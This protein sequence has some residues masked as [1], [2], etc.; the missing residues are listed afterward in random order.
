MF[1][2]KTIVWTTVVSLVISLVGM[3]VMKCSGPDK[4]AKPMT[5]DQQ[6]QSLEKA[7]AGSPQLQDFI[8]NER[9]AAKANRDAAE[10][11]Q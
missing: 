1:K 5:T 6:L 10:N 9:R 11:P 7:A 8:R 2:A 4:P 3:A